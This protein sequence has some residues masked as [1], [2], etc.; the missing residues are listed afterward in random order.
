MA[1]L[2]NLSRLKLFKYPYNQ[3]LALMLKEEISSQEANKK[4]KLHIP[5]DI[6]RAL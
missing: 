2:N 4:K 3:N 6:Q 5:G 1:P